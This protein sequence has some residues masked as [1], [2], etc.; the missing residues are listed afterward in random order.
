MAKTTL[1]DKLET[2]NHIRELEIKKPIKP[3]P[4]PRPKPGY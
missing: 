4:K 1:I 3:K 2:W